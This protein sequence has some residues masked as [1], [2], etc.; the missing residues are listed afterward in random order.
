MKYNSKPNGACLENSTSVHIYENEE[1]GPELK[2]RINHHIADNWDNFYQHK[3]GLPYKETVGVG[4]KAKTIE[5]N[6]K[7]EMIDF[8]RSEESLTVFSNYQELLAIANIFNIKISIF[9]YRDVHD[10]HW[11]EVTPDPDMVSD[12]EA[13]FGKWVPDMAL[14]NQDQTHY[15]LLV[16]DDSRIALLGLLARGQKEEM[17]NG[18]TLEEE[19]EQNDDLEEPE[20]NIDAN[21]QKVE[22]R[23]RRSSKDVQ[24]DEKLLTEDVPSDLSKDLVEE[25]SVL[26]NKTNGFRRTGPQELPVNMANSGAQFRCAKCDSVLE[27]EGLLDA[28][29]LS[30]QE[31][32]SPIFNCGICGQHCSSKSDMENHVIDEHPKETK[33][34]EW[35]CNDCPFQANS[36]DELMKHLRISGHQPSQLVNAKGK[37]ASDYKECY[38]CKMQFNG[39]FNLMEHRK[40][41]HPSTKRCRNFPASCTFGEKCWYVHEQP[42]EIDGENDVEPSPWNFKCNVCAKDFKERAQFMKHKKNDHPDANLE[43][44]NFKMGKC[45]RTED[46]CWFTHNF[47]NITESLSSEQVFQKASPNLFPP[48]QVLRMF[49]LVENLCQKMENME[50]RMEEMMD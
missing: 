16:R 7:S 19:H 31:V 23:K 18:A 11:R 12:T 6:T 9:T 46:A 4:E 28:H 15:D 45:K 43:C 13:K 14:Y 21:W 8:L 20:A 10:G 42:M 34:D 32:E 22:I 1:D 36:A 25:I 38:T 29:M 30:H 33:H 49:Q 3:I 40:N 37:H 39:Y 27:S 41:V 47:K 44:Q 26:K 2:K 50:K 17:T 5:K 48:E 24:I 35:I